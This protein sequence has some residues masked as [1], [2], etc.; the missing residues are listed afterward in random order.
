MEPDIPSS[1]Q[2]DPLKVSQ[3]VN[4]PIGNAYKFTLSGQ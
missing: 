2:H 3:I 4:N 1:L